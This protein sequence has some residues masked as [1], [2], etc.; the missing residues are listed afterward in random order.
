MAEITFAKLKRLVGTDKAKLRVFL[1]WQASTDER[2]A[3]KV[4]DIGSLRALEIANRLRRRAYAK[5][6]QCFLRTGFYST[7]SLPWS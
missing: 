6:E 4:H 7:Y 1:C 5:R 3:T 2:R